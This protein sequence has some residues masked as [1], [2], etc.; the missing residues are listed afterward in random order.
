VKAFPTHK[1]VAGEKALD[2]DAVLLTHGK[3]FVRTVAGAV[4]VD[5]LVGALQRLPH[6][7]RGEKGSNIHVSLVESFVFFCLCPRGFTKFG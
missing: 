4:E 7:K 5:L 6:V 1:I 3:N 2:W